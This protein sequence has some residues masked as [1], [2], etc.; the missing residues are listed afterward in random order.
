MM[1]LTIESK[2]KAKT[3][4]LMRLEEAETQIERPQTKM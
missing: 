4:L 3:D 2:L 1:F